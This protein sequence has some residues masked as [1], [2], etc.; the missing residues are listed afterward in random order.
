MRRLPPTNS[1]TAT[2]W[3]SKTDPYCLGRPLEPSSR[4]L[5]L[6][7][8]RPPNG[9]QEEGFA[10]ERHRLPGHLG[11]SANTRFAVVMC[12]DLSQLNTSTFDIGC[13]ASVGVAPENLR[14]GNDFLR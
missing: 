7:S 11:E 13:A 5:K 12:C 9:R 6:S 14:D 3:S 8:R 4:F 10:L 1:Q 2:P